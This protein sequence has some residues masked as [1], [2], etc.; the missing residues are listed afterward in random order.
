L[1]SIVPEDIDTANVS[2]Q[3]PWS[4]YKKN[5][6]ISFW[7]NPKTVTMPP[8]PMKWSR[9]ISCPGGN[10]DGFWNI[11]MYSNRIYF[12]TGDGL[13]FPVTPAFTVGS[14][15]HV[16]CTFN[17]TT[18]TR[19]IYSN[20][21]K[22]FGGVVNDY[23]GDVPIEQMPNRS[24]VL[25]ENLVKYNGLFSSL[26]LWD[27]ELSAQEVSTIFN[28]TRTYN[29]TSI[30]GLVG[31]YKFSASNGVLADSSGTNNHLTIRV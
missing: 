5:F 31:Y 20:G 23:R 12:G 11:A 24:S 6:S 8:E 22:I 27:K 21:T 3:I 30:P 9:F 17:L 13:S 16:V 28:G 14:W 2:Y 29:L 15:T 25:F 10:D 4:M 26:G 7:V 18:K 19:T 1:V